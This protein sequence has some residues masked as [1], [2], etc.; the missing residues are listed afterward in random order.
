M[1]PEATTLTGLSHRDYGLGAAQAVADRANR[2]SIVIYTLGAPVRRGLFGNANGVKPR[3]VPGRDTLALLAD[4][5][6]GLFSTNGPDELLQQA[7]ADQRGYY[8]LG[9]TPD[10]ASV[11]HKRHAIQVRVTRPGLT[12]RT[13]ARYY[14]SAERTKG[15]PSDRV[16]PASWAATSPFVQT[17]LAVALSASVDAGP[18]LGVPRGSVRVGVEGLTF[19][20]QSDG[21]TSVDLDVVTVAFRPTGV[22]EKV[23]ARQPKLQYTTEA[24]TELAD[25]GLDLD[26]HIAV[27]QPGLYRLHVVVKDVASGRVGSAD[28][29]VEV[30]PNPK[31]TA[32]L[33]PPRSDAADASVA[34]EPTQRLAVLCE[35]WGLLKYYH[36]GA[37]RRPDWDDVLIGAVPRFQ[38]ASSRTEL[39]NA[40][41]AIVHEAGD[42]ERRPDRAPIDPLFDWIDRAELGPDVTETL[43][44]IAAS[45]ALG[46]NRYVTRGIG[47]PIADFT[48]DQAFLAS[49]EYPGEAVRLL[50][51]FRFWNMAQYF[52]PYRDR[53]DDD[54]VEILSEMIPAFA[55]A[56]NALEYHLAAA[57]MAARLDDGHAR[58]S[59][60]VLQAY[61]G[62]NTVP[63]QMRRIEDRAVVTRVY[64]RLLDEAVDIRVGDVVTH[65]G[66]ALVDERRAALRAVVSGSNEAARERNI[67][68]RLV[69]TNEA[70][71]ALTVQRGDAAPFVVEANT[72]PVSALADERHADPDAWR[73]LPEEIGYVDMGRLRPVDVRAAME[74]LRGTRGIVFDVR[75]YPN[76]TMFLVS[77][78]LNPRGVPFVK[79][80]RP[81]FDHPGHFAW[82]DPI[83][84]GRGVPHPPPMTEARFLFEGPVA[85]LVNEETQSHAEYTVMALQTAPR[86]IVVGSPTAGADGNVTPIQLPGGLSASFSGLGVFY[87]DGRP[88]QRIGLVPDVTIRPTVRGLAEGRDEV[89]EAALARLR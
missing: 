70:R 45:E 88:T 48:A 77:S 28:T 73:V 9:Y 78:Y 40:V 72:V 15:L 64:R 65:V 17:G 50:A 27:R 83:A 81:D 82:T 34:I 84:T 1:D 79:F 12:V 21:T 80:Q 8:L 71:L 69:R 29:I 38:A 68:D 24:Q 25:R 67:H 47:A 26:F 89:L 85:I 44:A 10:P 3:D 57:A 7:L 16:D 49:P 31:A 18:R 76:G 59:S 4:E 41:L 66:R 39:E 22:V 5:T 14:A 62:L 42:V 2:G 11:R 87:P 60:D 52:F 51:L 36:G 19:K 86:A 56:A 33:T 46:S 54:W 55:G 75:N 13:R 20:P 58:A 37:A 6:G 32:A 74:R 30:R 63:I 61:F 53:M 35:V 43:K 23:V